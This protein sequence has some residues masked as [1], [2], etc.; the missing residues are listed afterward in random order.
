MGGDRPYRNPLT[1][2][3]VYYDRF[4]RLEA[5]FRIVLEN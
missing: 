5:D 4:R 2:K 1:P 3:P